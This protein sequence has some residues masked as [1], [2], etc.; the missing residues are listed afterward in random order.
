M[1]PHPS[2]KQ[3][4]WPLMLSCWRSARAIGC[5]L[6]ASFVNGLTFPWRT[7]CMEQR[8]QLVQILGER[9]RAR[10]PAEFVTQSLD[11]ANPPTLF[12]VLA[13]MARSLPDSTATGDAAEDLQFLQAGDSLHQPC[14][15]STD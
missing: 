8:R 15:R 10:V 12:L 13:D 3:L 7:A 5:M 1:L 14:S 2:V 11:A 4:M 6:C 9:A